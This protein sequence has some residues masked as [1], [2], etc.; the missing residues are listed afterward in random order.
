MKE[1]EPSILSSSSRGAAIPS[2]PII[3]SISSV[4]SQDMAMQDLKRKTDFLKNLDTK[5]LVARMHQLEDELEHSLIQE[6]EHKKLHAEYLSSYAS[7]CRAVDEIMATLEPPYREDGKAM[8][9]DQ[10]KVWLTRQ[11]KENPELVE[12][13]AKQHNVAFLN[14]QNHIKVET[15][16]KRLE[17]VRIVLTLKTAQIRFLTGE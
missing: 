11:R 2:L 9:V 12:A 15:V 8:T 6:S 3:Y 5:Q 4:H 17:G 1:N 16:L 14:D 10:R 13:I 7:D